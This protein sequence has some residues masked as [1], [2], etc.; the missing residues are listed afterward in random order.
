MNAVKDYWDAQGSGI[1]GIGQNAEEAGFVQLGEVL[2]W[3]K[4]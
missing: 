2:W 4:R 1:C 3:V